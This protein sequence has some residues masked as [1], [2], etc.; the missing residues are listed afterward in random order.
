MAALGMF[1]A[2]TSFTEKSKMLY[3]PEIATS[4]QWLKLTFSSLT[5]K[6]CQK[7]LEPFATLIQCLGSMITKKLVLTN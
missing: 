3:K 2:K 6:I 1:N 5:L 7:T 4:F